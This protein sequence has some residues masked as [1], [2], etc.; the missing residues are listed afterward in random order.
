MKKK[1]TKSTSNT[2]VKQKGK[3]KPGGMMSNS[4][5]MKGKCK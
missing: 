4:S 1:P 3:A 5:N 2:N